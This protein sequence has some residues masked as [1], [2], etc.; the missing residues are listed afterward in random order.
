VKEFIRYIGIRIGYS[1]EGGGIK[2]EPPGSGLGRGTSWGI[3][4]SLSC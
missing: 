1:L 4:G 2:V 3:I